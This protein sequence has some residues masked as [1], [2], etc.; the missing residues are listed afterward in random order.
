MNPKPVVRDRSDAGLDNTSC[1]GTLECL[2]SSSTVWRMS[3]VMRLYQRFASYLTWWLEN[4]GWRRA[5]AQVVVDNLGRPSGGTDPRAAEIVH[6]EDIRQAETL[7]LQP[8]ELV[9]VKSIDEILATLNR[10]RRCRGLLWMTGMRRFC[11]KRYRVLRRVERIMLETNGELR[12]MKNT[13]LLEGAMCDGTAF[14]GCDRSCFHF[15]REAWLRRVPAEED[16]EGGEI[17]VTEEDPIRSH[18]SRSM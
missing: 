16:S 11:G 14:G 7:G 8:G 12:T 18:M 5:L 17:H 13:V 1:H 6:S 10:K 4:L 9:E 15:W 3:P 2:R